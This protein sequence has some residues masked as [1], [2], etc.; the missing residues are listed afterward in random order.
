LSLAALKVIAAYLRRLCDFSN[1]C[2]GGRGR[3]LDIA[4]SL[5]PHVEVFCDVLMP[6]LADDKVAVRHHAAAAMSALVRAATLPPLID[7]LCG[8]GGLR[9]AA[10]RAREGAIRVFMAGL[11]W[12][13]TTSGVSCAAGGSGAGGGTAASGAE[14][15]ARGRPRVRPRQQLPSAAEESGRRKYCLRC[16][17]K[18]VVTSLGAMPADSHPEVRE[19]AMA[20]LALVQAVYGDEIDVIQTLQSKGY[21]SFA[22]TAAA[23]TTVKGGGAGITARAQAE[24]MSAL[25][26]RLSQPKIDMPVLSAEGLVEFRHR[27]CVGNGA[28]GSGGGGGGGSGGGGDEARA[29]GAQRNRRSLDQEDSAPSAKGA[30]RGVVEGAAAASGAGSAMPTRRHSVDS[31]GSHA[32]SGRQPAAGAAG[33]GGAAAVTLQ[34]PASDHAT[35]ARFGVSNG[36]NEAGRQAA[37]DWRA[38]TWGFETEKL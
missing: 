11:L 19:V 4:P 18:V 34:R 25:L 12:D 26:S 8:R 13:G 23:G 14:D 27:R 5:Q 17:P 24:T 15:A 38:K 37:E 28:L 1:D 33:S 30:A 16:D 2:D 20:A 22:S 9:S 35:N 29:N 32:S 31:S 10:W 6:K 21:L 36:V 3:G 7:P